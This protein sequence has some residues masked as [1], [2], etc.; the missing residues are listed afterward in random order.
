MITAVKLTDI[1]ATHGYIM[2]MC[3]RYDKSLFGGW[4]CHV[5]CGILVPQPRIELWLKA[6]KVLSINDWTARGFLNKSISILERIQHVYF[7]VAR[8]LLAKVKVTQS[9][10]TFCDPMAYSSPGS[11]VHGILQARMLKWFAIPFSM[12]SFDLRIEPESPADSLLSE[13]PES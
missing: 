6:V 9:C 4:L 12:G 5:A 10:P 7:T 2:N 3:D 1:S 13:S 11:S 8:A